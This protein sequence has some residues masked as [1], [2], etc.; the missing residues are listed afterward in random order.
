MHEQNV[1]GAAS[2]DEDLV[3]LGILDDG[4]DYERI[5][6]WLWNKVWVVTAVEGDGDL[7]PLKVLSGGV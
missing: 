2:I 4:A 5:P 1:Q 6:P 3:E 7:G